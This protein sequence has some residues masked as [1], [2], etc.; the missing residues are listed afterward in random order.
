[1]SLFSETLV[2]DMRRLPGAQHSFLHQLC[3]PQA[4]R[5]RSVLEGLVSSVA[6]PLAERARPLLT[7]LDNRRFFQ[8]YGEIAVASALARGRM[9][10]KDVVQPGAYLE[11]HSLGGEIVNVAVLSFIH[12][13]RGRADRA[14]VDRLVGALN[15]VGSSQRIVV[16]VHGRLPHD[17]DTEEIR[18]AVDT[19]LDEAERG[20][21]EGR[22]ATFIDE[23]RGIHLEFGITGRTSRHGP[24]VCFH[25]GPFDGPVSLEAVEPRLLAEL[26]R[27]H[28]GPH[29][30]RPLLLACVADQPWT[31]CPGYMRDFLYGQARCMEGYRDGSASAI[32]LT[33]RDGVSPTLFRDPVYADLAGILW[34]D[35]SSDDPVHVRMR[36]HLNPW[37]REPFD[38]SL[39]TSFPVLAAHRRVGGETVLRWHGDRKEGRVSLL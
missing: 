36:G 23:K 6:A 1:M 29:A 5:H 39:L 10:V 14:T 31:V 24:R 34:L 37:A 11:A 27:Y 22:Y 8:G 32:E 13:G 20:L 26:E 15:R 12:R 21:W 4:G 3:G 28:L 33:Y 16:V 35:R 38:P 30:G 7:S 25:M 9:R 17:F 2:E 19:W 18:R